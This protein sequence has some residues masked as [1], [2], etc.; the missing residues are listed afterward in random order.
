MQW[1][2]IVALILAIP[3]FVFPVVF[4]WYINI[5]GAYEVSRR[6]IRARKTRQGDC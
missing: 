1:E 3:I 2:F 4:I 5:K 6:L